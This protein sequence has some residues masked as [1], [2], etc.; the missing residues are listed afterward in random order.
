M[1]VCY[2]RC[3]CCGRMTTHEVCHEHSAALGNRMPAMVPT[4]E[5]QD[6][7]TPYYNWAPEVWAHG[8]SLPAE[9]CADKACKQLRADWR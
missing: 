6:D 9:V 8:F 4:G 7:G 5:L 3:I 1:I 2:S